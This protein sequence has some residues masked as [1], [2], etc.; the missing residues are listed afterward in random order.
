MNY[1][2]ANTRWVGSQL[3]LNERSDYKKVWNK[4]AQD[5]EVATLAI[6]GARDAIDLE[7]M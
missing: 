6:V 5:V 2:E 1:D 4:Q 7:R 3:P